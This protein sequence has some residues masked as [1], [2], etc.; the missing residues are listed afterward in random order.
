MRAVQQTTL[1]AACSIGNG[2]VRF[3]QHVS[4]WGWQRGL[5]SLQQATL[6]DLRSDTVTMPSDQMRKAMQNARVGDDVAGE[7]PTV[8]ELEALAASMLG[9]EEALYVPTGTMGNMVSLAAHL[10]RGDEL[11]LGTVVP[12]PVTRSKSPGNPVFFFSVCV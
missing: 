10:R 12:N 9:F 5:C 1:R 3:S 7:D 2:R 4:R 8:N 6:I 11:I